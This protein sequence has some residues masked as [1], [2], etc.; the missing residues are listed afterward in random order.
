M[1]KKE[2]ATTET[3]HVR[4]LNEAFYDIDQITD[5][6]ANSS[7]Q[8]LNAVIVIE[9]IFE[10]INKIGQ[11]PLAY[12]ECA[13]LPTKTKI[14]RRAACLSW[15]IIYKITKPE[16]LILGVIHGSRNPL[17]IRKFRKVK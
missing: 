5:F 7:R 3:G 8:P 16:I 6:I 1:G 17:K 9:T 12:R 11:N 15:I 4:I 13:Q 14:Y 10:T 2:K